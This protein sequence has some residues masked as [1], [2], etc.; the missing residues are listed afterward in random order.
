[1]SKIS[2][3]NRRHFDR[4]DLARLFLT[5]KINGF[6]PFP[7]LGGLEPLG[8]SGTQNPKTQNPKANKSLPLAV[9]ETAFLLFLFPFLVMG[10]VGGGEEPFVMFMY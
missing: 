4:T 7:A 10:Q 2:G 1:M 6:L 8:V 9:F 3:R 5:G